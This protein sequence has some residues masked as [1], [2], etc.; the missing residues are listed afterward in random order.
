MLT[1]PVGQE[2]QVREAAAVYRQEDVGV[3]IALQLRLKRRAAESIKL[4]FVI[5]R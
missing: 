3:E 5:L 4:L 1:C 2:E